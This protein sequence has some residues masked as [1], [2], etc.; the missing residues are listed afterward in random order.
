MASLHPT[1]PAPLP[2]RSDVDPERFRR[3]IEPGY[4][5][6][7]L[8]GLARDWPAVAAARTG[9]AQLAAY[10]ARFDRGASVEAFIGPRGDARTIFLRCRAA[11]LQFPAQQGP[12]RRSARFPA[13]RDR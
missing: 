1:L 5:P 13:A 12:P 3:E 4:R 2:E 6:V 11:R 10:L 8:R 9:P 7:V